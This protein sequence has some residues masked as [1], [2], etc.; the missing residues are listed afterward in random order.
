MHERARVEVGHIDRPFDTQSAPR[1]PSSRRPCQQS[2]ERRAC[3]DAPGRARRPLGGERARTATTRRAGGVA[4]GA[5]PTPDACAGHPDP[6]HA[7]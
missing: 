7:R 2:D 4:H 3:P 6:V 1:E 5:V